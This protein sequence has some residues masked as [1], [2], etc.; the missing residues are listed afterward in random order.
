MNFLVLPVENWTREFEAKL[1]LIEN[2]QKF[3]KDKSLV[4][5]APKRIVNILT[6][7]GLRNAGILHKSIQEKTADSVDRALKKQ[8]SYFFMEEEA[9][10]RGVSFDVRTGEKIPN[11]TLAL[12]TTEDDHISLS[13]VFDQKKIAKTG[14]PRFDFLFQNHPV[15]IKRQQKI[16]S[17]FGNF[18][19]F[20]SNFS[21]VFAPEDH[22]LN[23]LADEGIWKNGE[24]KRALY[25]YIEDHKKRAL[26]VCSW[27]IKLSQ[28]ETVIY[29]PHPQESLEKVSD[30]FSNS[31][32]K[33]IRDDSIIPWLNTCSVL[34]HCGCTSGIEYANLGK[35]PIF[36]LPLDAEKKSLPYE[37]SQVCNELEHFGEIDV[38]RLSLTKEQTAEIFAK[39]F[40]PNFFEIRGDSAAK[41]IKAILRH[42][43]KASFLWLLINCMQ[44]VILDVWFRRKIKRSP[45]EFARLIDSP[46]EKA[47]K[48]FNLSKESSESN[49]KGAI[50]TLRLGRYCLLI[51]T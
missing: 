25:E 22:S 16:K 14:N 44:V 11:V 1:H 13:K 3:A 38:N 34:L 31:N 27:L 9:I 48:W 2:I 21:L 42:L 18:K 43:P 45:K 49:E 28:S 33:I 5:L 4:L 10:H 41:T 40:G 39:T 29:R 7:Y 30:F 35:R 47:Q 24:E 15:H 51:I 50:R 20:S 12:A 32:V 46:G 8:C 19:F 23:N 26:V 37:V 6:D 17:D 36:L